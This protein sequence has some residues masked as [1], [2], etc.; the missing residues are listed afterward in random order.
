MVNLSEYL[1]ELKIIEKNLNA[2]KDPINTYAWICA[3]ET[4]L[5][6]LDNFLENQKHLYYKAMVNSKLNH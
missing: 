6:A 1:K 5:H 4:K 3:L 2:S